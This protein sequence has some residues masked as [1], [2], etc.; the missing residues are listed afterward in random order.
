MNTVFNYI[1]GITKPQK[2]TTK[3]CKCCGKELPL[4]MFHKKPDTK[5]GLN[6][7]CKEC[8]SVNGPKPSNAG[9]MVMKANN[10]TRPK[11]G[12]PC[13]ICG[14]TTK[15]LYC[16]HDHEHNVFR[17][18]LCYDCNTA[19]GKLKD[20]KEFIDK[21]AWYMNRAETR[22]NEHYTSKNYTRKRSGSP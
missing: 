1:D 11:L 22:I 9:R 13:E 4:N 3:T 21:A 16:D 18:W 12:T 6:P 15:K 20:K 8:R 5:D 10:L 19:L 17:G 14:D 2:V 7:V